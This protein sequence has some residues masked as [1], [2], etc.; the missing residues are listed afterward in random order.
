MISIFLQK[1]DS[2][3][4][5]DKIIKY[6]GNNYSNFT[7]GELRGGHLALGEIYLANTYTQILLIIIKNFFFISSIN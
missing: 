5:E 6:Q 1:K 3:I 4:L 2:V 7:K